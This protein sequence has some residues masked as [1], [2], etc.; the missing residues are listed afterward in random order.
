MFDMYMLA[1]S[2]KGSKEYNLLLP[3]MLAFGVFSAEIAEA[4]SEISVFIHKRFNHKST[5]F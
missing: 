1:Q 4:S 2:V 5:V 3:L